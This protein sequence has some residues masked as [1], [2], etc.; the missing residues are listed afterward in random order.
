MTSFLS[1][2]EAKLDRKLPPAFLMT[3]EDEY[4]CADACL[5]GMEEGEFDV[6]AQN[7]PCRYLWEEFSLLPRQWVRLC[8]ILHQRRIAS[9]ILWYKMSRVHDK[10]ELADI[11][12]MWE[13]LERIQRVLT[14]W[15]NSVGKLNC[16]L[17]WIERELERRRAWFTG[18]RRVWLLAAVQM[19]EQCISPP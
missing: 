15:R 19:N 10:H 2:A 3:L 13:D 5:G 9:S 1:F 18:L 4:V 14:M 11:E 6:L 8:A 7:D 12:Y 16:R 17:D